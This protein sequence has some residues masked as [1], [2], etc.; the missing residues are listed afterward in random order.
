MGINGWVGGWKGGG[1]GWDGT[2][3]FI[4]AL[5]FAFADIR[6]ATLLYIILHLHT[7]VMRHCCTFS[8]ICTHKHY[9][10]LLSVLS[11]LHVGDDDDEDEV[12]HEDE[13]EEEEEEEEYDDDDD[14]DNDD[15]D[16]DDDDDV[17]DDDDDDD[18]NGEQTIF[19][20][21]LNSLEK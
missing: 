18:G 16:T 3:T 17:D 11:H 14:D 6:H 15:D 5:S 20:H 13:G 10:R 12:G 19:W 21:L 8:S 4:A 7:Y 1:V 2:I 9:V